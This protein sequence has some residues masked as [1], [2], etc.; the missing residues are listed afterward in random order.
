MASAP[1][2][3]DPQGD[4][5]DVVLAARL[6]GVVDEA[7][8]DRGDLV[9]GEEL[10]HAVVVEVAVQAVGAD[11]ELVARQ[12]V[13]VDGVDLD[14]LV[15]AD[16]PGDG[17]L[18]G[19]VGGAGQVV[20]GDLAA[21]DQ[22]VDE[23]VVL[24]ELDD[25]GLAQQVDPA[26]ADVGDEPAVADHHEGR[27]GGPHA[28][29]CPAPAC[30]ARRWRSPAA[31]TPCS[32]SA[33]ISCGAGRGVPAWCSPRGPP[34]WPLSHCETHG[35]RCAMP[36]PPRRAPPCRRPRRKRELLVDEEVVL[37][38]LALAPDVRSGPEAQLHMSLSARRAVAS[39]SLTL[40][41]ATRQASPAAEAAP[42]ASIARLGQPGESL[43]SGKKHCYKCG[44]RGAGL[45]GDRL[46]A[47]RQTLDLA[48][49]VRILVPEPG[50][51]SPPER[52]KPKKHAPTR[53]SKTE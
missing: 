42:T 8:G 26:V 50:E 34:A 47:G 13:E 53:A 52:E 4:G 48:I 45:L 11:Q 49:K 43:D 2:L 18:V 25:L 35:R 23:R 1:R 24:G 27:D 44:S 14:R 51:C 17:V 32:S 46:T 38:V 29:A 3:V 10:A 31:W 22:L 19:V 9:A 15:D 5:G 33:R 20:L 7:L 6:V 36:P 30:P 28:R 39:S 37:V 40:N 12:D 21:P 16:R 41:W